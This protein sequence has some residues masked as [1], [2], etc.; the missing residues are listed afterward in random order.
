MAAFQASHRTALWVGVLRC[1]NSRSAL[2][3]WGF[4]LAQE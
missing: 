1:M 2:S 3:G 4:F